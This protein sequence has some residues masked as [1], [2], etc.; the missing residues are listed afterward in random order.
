ML[1]TIEVIS[2]T[3]T[4]IKIKYTTEAML[5]HLYLF[6]IH[7]ERTNGQRILAKGCVAAEQI[8]HRGQCNVMPLLR[9]E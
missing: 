2:E 5:I 6:I 8:F 3:R 7:W 9:S 1:S 4:G